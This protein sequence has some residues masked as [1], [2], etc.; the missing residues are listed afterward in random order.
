MRVKV[1]PDLSKIDK[2]SYRISASEYKYV[3]EENGI[4]YKKLGKDRRELIQIGCECGLLNYYDVAYM[5]NPDI[6]YNDAEK[7]LSAKRISSFNR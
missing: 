6:S 1:K 5:G 3:L 4:E 2:D 7:R